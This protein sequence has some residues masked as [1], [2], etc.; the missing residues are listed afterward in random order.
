MVGA[1]MWFNQENA[2]ADDVRVAQMTSE[3]SLILIQ[4]ESTEDKIWRI[5]QQAEKEGRPL[6]AEEKEKIAKLE[7]R[8]RRLEKRYD[9]LEQQL[10]K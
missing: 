5:R 1:V 4:Q 9:L 8:T 10:L 6:T 7:K 2:W 3:Q